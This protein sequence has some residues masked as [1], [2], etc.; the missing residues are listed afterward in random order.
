MPPFLHV[1][2][3]DPTPIWAQV[4]Q[5]VRGMVANGR[6]AA[7]TP[8][9]SVRDLA[10]DLRLNPATVARAYQHL[11][12]E[13]ILV[14]RRGEGTFVA[15]ISPRLLDEGRARALA[16]AA[17]RFAAEARGIGASDVEA[18]RAIELALEEGRS[19]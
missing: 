8:V 9:P 2:P 6:L 7:G 10:R 1:D 17:A 11:Q 12:G 13:G 14:V 16:A 3:S 19:R 15:S 5:R 4:A 18:V